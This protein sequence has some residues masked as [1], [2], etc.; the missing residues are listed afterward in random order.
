MYNYRHFK[1][2]D[3]EFEREVGPGVGDSLDFEAR[4]LEGRVVQLSD[5]RGRPV[6]LETGSVTCGIYAD[7]VDCWRK[8]AARSPEASFV[9][10]YVR[11]AHP[12]GRTGAHRSWQEKRE[13]A[14]QLA[15]E[16]GEWREIW[17]DDLDGTAH[18]MM[19]SLPVMMYVLNAEGRIALRANWSDP[20]AAGQALDCLRRGN[21]PAGVVVQD[22]L[23]NPLI[24][25]RGLFKGGWRAV[26]DFALAVPF[27]VPKRLRYRRRLRENHRDTKT[28]GPAH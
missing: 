24:A 11:E 23:P 17:V 18:R 1:A 6:V 26:W 19:G 27:L 4:N 15:V 25:L 16:W 21:D 28:G 13:A 7:K 20:D 8:I 2:R 10:L 14:G 12:G 22:S 3:Y 9:L 5:L